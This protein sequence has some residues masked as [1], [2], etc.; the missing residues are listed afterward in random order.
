MTEKELI[1]FKIKGSEMKRKKVSNGG[2]NGVIY[3]PKDWI[4]EEVDV[5]RKE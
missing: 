1:E 2:K 5:I 3:V 4:G